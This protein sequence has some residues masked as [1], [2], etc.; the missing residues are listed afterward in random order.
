MGYPLGIIAPLCE[1]AQYKQTRIAATVR[2]WRF[3][4]WVWAFAL[5]GIADKNK[6]SLRA[7]ELAR[8]KPVSGKIV[9]LEYA[10]W[11]QFSIA[12]ALSAAFGFYRHAPESSGRHRQRSLPH[13]VQYVLR[14]RKAAF[15]K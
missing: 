10:D 14:N 15:G 7:E 6:P 11:R 4:I 1:R 9:M 2:R 13:R 8:F 12:G 3:S 5:I